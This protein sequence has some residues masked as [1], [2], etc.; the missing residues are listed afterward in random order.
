MSLAQKSTK[1]G[2]TYRHISMSQE[3]QESEELELE[4]Q[5]NL[6]LTSHPHQ[7]GTDTEVRIAKEQSSVFELL[8]RESRGNLVLAPDFQ[9]KDVWDRKHQSELIES[10]LMG[11]PI[12][13]IYLFEDENGVRQI[14][15]GKQR[16]SALKLYIN[17]KFALTD[18][19]MFPNLKGKKFDDIPHLLQSKLEDYQLHSYVIQPPTPEYVKFNIFE[20]VNRGGI[21]LNKQEMR[22][23]LYQGKA[24]ILIQELAE[25]EEF[26]LS[27]GYG[28]KSERMRDRY[29]ILRF[30]SFYLYMMKGMSMIEY[31]SDIDVFLA[32]TMKFLNTK[33]TPNQLEEVKQACLKGM[34]NVYELLGSEAF[35]FKPKHGGNRRPINMGLF[36]MLVFA[37]CF[38]DLSKL[39]KE[40]DY[41]T[42]VESYKENFEA[43]GIFSGSIDTLEYVK[44]RF[45]FSLEITRGLKNAYQD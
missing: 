40:N 14:I 18:L 44:M 35:R 5:E 19:S 38:I 32:S 33:A 24:S 26:K 13:L 9:R 29:L 21:N 7:M 27:T 11:I 12:P 15:D 22:H 42:F 43:L 17:N 36:E 20:R 1:N 2:I 16:I 34:Y 31:K 28:V 41:Y 30:V 8:R 23:A 6:E 25:S 39:K 4:D 10:I 3:I 37:L 45:D